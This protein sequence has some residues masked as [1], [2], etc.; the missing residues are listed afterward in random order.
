MVTIYVS[1]KPMIPMTNTHTFYDT[2]PTRSAALLRI[3]VRITPMPG[4]AS[5]TFTPNRPSKLAKALSLF[6]THS[7]APFSYL[8]EGLPLVALLCHQEAMLQPKHQ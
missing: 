6:L 8:G 4:S 7:I 3:Q 2:Q 1:R 5:A